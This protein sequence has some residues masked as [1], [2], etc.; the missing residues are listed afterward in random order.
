[1]LGQRNEEQN[2]KSGFDFSLLHIKGN[3]PLKHEFIPLIMDDAA[4]KVMSV[5]RKMHTILPFT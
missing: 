2:E 4:Q 3:P 1:M 5:F